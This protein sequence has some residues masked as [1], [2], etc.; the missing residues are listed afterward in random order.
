[1]DFD[2]ALGH[3]PFLSFPCRCHCLTFSISLN[4]ARGLW[5]LENYRNHTLYDISCKTED[6]LTRG[7]REKSPRDLALQTK[8][9][10]IVVAIKLR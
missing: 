6:K 2:F 4:S 10:K 8:N 1:M 5:E 9:M 7:K 3:A